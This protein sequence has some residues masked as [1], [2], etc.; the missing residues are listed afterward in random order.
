MEWKGVPLCLAQIPN[1][2][3]YNNQVEVTT[4]R[5]PENGFT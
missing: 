2:V 3:I 5:V 4:F 1:L